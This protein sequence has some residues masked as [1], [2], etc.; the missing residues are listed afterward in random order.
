MEFSFCSHIIAING[1]GILLSG[2]YLDDMTW[3]S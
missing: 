3:E 2:F 1:T